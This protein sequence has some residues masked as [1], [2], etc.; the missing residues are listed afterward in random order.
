MAKQPKRFEIGQRVQR[1]QL[2]HPSN[3]EG[4]VT[5]KAA[6]GQYWVLFDGQ[7]RPGLCHANGLCAAA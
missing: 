7:E 3:R 6:R 5:A 2:Y 1:G 4:V